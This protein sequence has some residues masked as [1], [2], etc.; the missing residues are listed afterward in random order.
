MTASATVFS[1]MSAI[2]LITFLIIFL[3]SFYYMYSEI[4]HLISV[5][6]F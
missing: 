4:G 5:L 2:F 6:E 3:I 1:R